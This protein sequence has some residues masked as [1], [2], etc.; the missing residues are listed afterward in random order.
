M[1]VYDSLSGKEIQSLPAPETM[2]GVYYDANL[3]RVYM[4]GGRWYGTPN[5]SP[6]WIYDY[7]QKDPDHCDLISKIKTRPGSG[8]GTPIQSLL[9]RLSG[10]RW[11]GGRDTGIRAGAM[12]IIPAD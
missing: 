12:R 5:A 4:T 7:Q 9:C 2:D 8:T 6:G 3:A 10:N 11:S 1:T